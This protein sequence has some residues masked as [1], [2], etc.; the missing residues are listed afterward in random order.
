[1][2]TLNFTKSGN[3][4]VSDTIPYSGNGVTVQYKVPA[5]TL[6]SEKMMLVEASLDGTNWYALGTLST[7]EEVIKSITGGTS[8]SMR[9]KCKN[10]PLLA[11][12]IQ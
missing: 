1:M 12:Y 6:T 11:Q 5:S 9:L 8:M 7:E 3:M 4:Y 2:I 10:M